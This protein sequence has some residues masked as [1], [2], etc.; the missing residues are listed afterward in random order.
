MSRQRAEDRRTNDDPHEEQQQYAGTECDAD[1]GKEFGC[2][3]GKAHAP[4]VDLD[5]S[6]R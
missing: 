2:E 1:Q 5:G 4:R 3:L 6:V